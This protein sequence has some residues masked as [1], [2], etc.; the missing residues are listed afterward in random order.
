MRV[1][2]SVCG[3]SRTEAR[4]SS[5]A[6]ESL[7]LQSKHGEMGGHAPEHPLCQQQGWAA[8]GEGGGVLSGIP[9]LLPLLQMAVLD[10]ASLHRARHGNSELGAEL[11]HR[12]LS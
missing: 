12:S 11:L 6:K 10:A 2:P 5:E 3:A 1:L 8:L 9:Q 7:T 4:F